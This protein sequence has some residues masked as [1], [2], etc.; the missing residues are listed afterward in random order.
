MPGLERL[1]HASSRDQVEGLQLISREPCARHSEAA[2]ANSSEQEQN[3]PQ[4]LA[5]TEINQSDPLQKRQDKSRS[6]QVHK[7]EVLLQDESKLLSDK[8]QT[9]HKQKLE[10]GPLKQEKKGS[11]QLRY[12]QV[13]PYKAQ[14]P[15]IEEKI[16]TLPQQIQSHENI[17]RHV[18]ENSKAQQERIRIYGSNSS[19]LRLQKEHH[20]KIVQQLQ[21]ENDQLKNDQPENDQLKNNQPEY[22]L[23]TAAAEQSQADNVDLQSIDTVVYFDLE[24]GRDWIYCVSK[25]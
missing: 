11:E 22:I 8:H 12:Q 10:A 20:I 2:D 19:N 14:Q 5:F 16:C 25:K 21:P 1:I 4:S 23:S 3:T 24:V 6:V 9:L 7:H 15:G 13:L 18:T 17:T